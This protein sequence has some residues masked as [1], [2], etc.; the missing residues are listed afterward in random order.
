MIFSAKKPII[1]KI[2]TTYQDNYLN[3]KTIKL[4]KYLI[5]LSINIDGRYTN[6]MFTNK[7]T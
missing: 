1:N 3:K 7:E 5:Y 4:L 2:I 6:Y